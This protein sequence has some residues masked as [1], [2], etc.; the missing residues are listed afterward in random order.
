M[1]TNNMLMEFEIEIPKQSR[2]TLQKPCQLLSPDSEKSNRAT[3]RPFW[4]WHHWKSI[5]FFWYTQVMC[6]W[7]LDSIFT[8][9]LKLE[10]GNQK[11]QYG[12][13]AAILKV[14][15]LKINRL[16][17]IATNNMLVKFEIEIPKQAWVTL[18]KP[19]RLQT[20]G[21]TDRRTDG[22]TDGQTDRRTGR[23]TRWIQYTPPITSLGGGGGGGGGISG[24]IITHKQQPLKTFIM[25]SF[26]KSTKTQ[27]GAIYM[28]YKTC[29]FWP[30]EYFFWCLQMPVHTST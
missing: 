21:Q 19:C 25:K 11:I 24:G 9:K 17:P 18:R 28:T 27:F 7:S 6:Q 10:S 23:R 2:V 15:S 4:K 5:D 3:R 8:A 20:D 16:L 13:Q 1:A 12:R 26:P 30:F 22:Q 29:Q 14:T